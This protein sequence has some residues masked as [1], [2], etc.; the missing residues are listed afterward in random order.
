MKAAGSIAGKGTGPV[1]L[2]NGFK[3]L[4]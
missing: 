1:M 2:E 4:A 3:K